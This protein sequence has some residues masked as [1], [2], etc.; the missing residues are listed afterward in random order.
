MESPRTNG[1]QH[2]AA[3]AGQLLVGGEALAMEGDPHSKVKL[4]KQNK[5]QVN[6]NNKNINSLK[7][8]IMEAGMFLRMSSA[9]MTMKKPVI[10]AAMFLI[11][12]FVKTTL[13]MQLMKATMSLR[14]SSAKTT[15][16]TSVIEAAMIL[17]MCFVKTT[18]KMPMMKP[19]ISLRMSLAKM[20]LKKYVMPRCSG[21]CAFSRHP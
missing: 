20:T 2:R 8:P 12:F 14:T 16:K 19:A 4:L 21:R 1:E 3:M 5:C 17:M 9:K 15:M 10:K 13:K 7:K 11:M 6:P 18:Q